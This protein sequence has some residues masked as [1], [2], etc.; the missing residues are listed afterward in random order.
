MVAKRVLMMVA[1]K[2]VERVLR[3]AGWMENMMAAGKV[4]HLA[5]KRAV[6]MEE[7]TDGK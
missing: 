6:W 3:K 1:K 4:Y 7:T 2:A 5:E